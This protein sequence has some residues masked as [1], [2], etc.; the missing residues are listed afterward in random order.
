MIK[1]ITFLIGMV[2]IPILAYS[3]VQVT[4]HAEVGYLFFRKQHII[5]DPGPNFQGYFLEGV[6]GGIHINNSVGITNKKQ[7]YFLGAGAG[8][9]KLK[10]NVGNTFFFNSNIRFTKAEDTGVFSFKLG[11]SSLK[12]NDGRTQKTPYAEIKLGI[13]SIYNKNWGLKTEFGTSMLQESYFFIGSI[14]GTYTFRK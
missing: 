12:K 5:Y 11:T 6:D 3:Q 9:L 1:S 8:Y 14:T 4:N 10:N 13:S 2:V 7:R